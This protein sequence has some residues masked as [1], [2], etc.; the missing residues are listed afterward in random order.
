MMPQGVGSFSTP[1]NALLRNF[2]FL[3]FVVPEKGKFLF[4]RLC[5]IPN[6][7]G[8]ERVPHASPRAHTWYARSHGPYRAFGRI[9]VFKISQ[10]SIDFDRKSSI[11]RVGGSRDPKTS[12]NCLL[13]AMTPLR[14]CTAKQ[15]KVRLTKENPVRGLDKFND[16]L[17]I[18]IK[19]GA[20]EATMRQSTGT[21]YFGLFR[22]AAQTEYW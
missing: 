7:F 3:Y 13:L 1:G 4:A 2:I 16:D 21:L 14:D 18:G 6:K 12:K 15:W 10:F 19:A 5:S 17:F 20:P 11:S 9:F 22:R 8:P